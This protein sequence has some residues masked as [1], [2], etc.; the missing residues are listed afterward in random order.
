MFNVQ[1][2]ESGVCIVVV[3]EFR[4]TNHALAYKH[5]VWTSFLPCGNVEAHET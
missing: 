4:I 1:C 2:S 5:E 3:V